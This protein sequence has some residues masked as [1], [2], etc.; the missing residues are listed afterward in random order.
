MPSVI[1]G[2]SQFAVAA[3]ENRAVSAPR[4]STAWMKRG[5]L[6]AFVEA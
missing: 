6:R 4:P 3:R 2:I 5:Q 1:A